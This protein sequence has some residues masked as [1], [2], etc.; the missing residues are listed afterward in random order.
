[1]TGETELQWCDKVGVKPLT[2]NILF[3]SDLMNGTI[4]EQEKAGGGKQD[5]TIN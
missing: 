4:P 5:D 1:M 2:D 3:T